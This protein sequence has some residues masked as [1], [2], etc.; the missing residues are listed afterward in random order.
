M[1]VIHRRTEISV[2]ET[3]LIL[4]C[5]KVELCRYEAEGPARKPL[6]GRMTNLAQWLVTCVVQ[7]LCPHP[8][9]VRPTMRSARIEATENRPHA[10]RISVI[11]EAQDTDL[12]L[13]CRDT[14]RV[15]PSVAI[16]SGVVRGQLHSKSNWPS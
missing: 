7:K 6:P 5:P 4:Q 9:P 2:G 16:E 3:A 8:A 13:G 11:F 15:D 12:K 1:A 14:P 10:H